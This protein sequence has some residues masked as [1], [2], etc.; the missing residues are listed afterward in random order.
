MKFGLSS[1]GCE[2]RPAK[3]EPAQPVVSLATDAVTRPAMR[4]RAKVW[5]VG[6]AAT[7]TKTFWVP[8]ASICLKARAV[9]RESGRGAAPSGV[10]DHGTQQEDGPG[11]WEAHVP[12]RQSSGATETRLSLSDAPRARGC[13][14]GRPTPRKW[15]RKEE[16]ST[17][18]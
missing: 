4:R 9:S 2:P 5:A 7:K 12:P 10:Y 18:R 6:E 15:L 17:S 16:A 13:A 11:T 14:C 8:R 1:S 3:G